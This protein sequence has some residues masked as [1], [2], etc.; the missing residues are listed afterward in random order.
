MYTEQKRRIH[1]WWCNHSLTTFKITE[2]MNQNAKSRDIMT[3]QTLQY[4]IFP[5]YIV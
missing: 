1:F 2:N 5:I 4:L 3:C